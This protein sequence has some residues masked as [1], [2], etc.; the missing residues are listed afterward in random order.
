MVPISSFE[1]ECNFSSRGPDTFV[2]NNMTQRRVNNF[3]VCHVHQ[4]IIDVL[5]LDE[6]ADRFVATSDSQ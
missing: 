1:A 2:T 5:N 4:D 3:A 6:L